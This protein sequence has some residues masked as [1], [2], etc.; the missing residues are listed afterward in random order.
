M[1][2]CYFLIEMVM[3]MNNFYIRNWT[4]QLGGGAYLKG[5]SAVVE[6][7]IQKLLLIKG[8]LWWDYGRGIVLT[9]IN[10]TSLYFWIYE[11]VNETPFIKRLTNFEVE[12]KE[13]YYLVTIGL[14]FESG[15][16]INTKFNLTF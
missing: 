8:E 5:Q 7:L 12:K 3:A 9:N 1:T 15:E 14:E 10:E 11:N 13:Y 16:K 2:L 4:K 6:Y